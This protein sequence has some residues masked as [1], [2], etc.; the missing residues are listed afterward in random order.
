[1]IVP[2]IAVTRYFVQTKFAISGGQKC[3]LI[4]HSLAGKY[5]NY[6]L[7]NFFSGVQEDLENSFPTY[8]ENS[9]L[10]I[11]WTKHLPLVSKILK[12]N[13]VSVAR[14][15]VEQIEFV[16]AHRIRRGQQMITLYSR[17]WE[18][19]DLR[20]LLQKIKS[21]FKR[22]TKFMIGT[23]FV[24]FNWE[25]ERITVDEMKR[26][27]DEMHLCKILRS[28]ALN[29][30]NGNHKA[31]SAEP[32]CT[33]AEC[34]TDSSIRAWEPFIIEEDLTVWKMQDANYKTTGLFCY[35]LYGKYDDITADDFLQVF[36]DTEN[37]TKWD[38][39]AADLK[40]IDSEPATQSEVIYW[41]TRWPTLFSNRDYVFKRRYYKDEVNQVI[42]VM[43]KSTEHPLYPPTS[44]KARVTEYWSYMVIKAKNN[45]DEP[46]MEF[47]LTYYDNPGIA[48]PSALSLWVTVQGMP[49]YLKRLR[50]EALA[51]G[52]KRKLERLEE[53]EEEILK[54]KERTCEY[55][56]P[57]T[58]P[59]APSSPD[60]DSHLSK[61]DLLFIFSSYFQKLRTT[62]WL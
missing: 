5:P 61:Y 36:L 3:H 25:N 19:K 59:P 17:L 50:I 29:G 27:L 60:H 31:G 24:A 57:P 34:N 55:D 16:L 12:F 20:R 30:N 6:S 10:I 43:N 35:K 28:K 58:P 9:L 54:E 2:F 48:L 15:C 62:L 4:N 39:H 56:R 13:S 41:E 45:M 42:I 32:E 46:G 26:H 52:E 23:S 33:C 22:K 51:I 44:A 47:S 21:I 18:E 40:V 1:M 8:K 49:E 14:N 53:V 7:R 38:T 37:R 11:F